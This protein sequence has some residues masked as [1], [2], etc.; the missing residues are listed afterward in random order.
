MKINNKH[1]FFAMPFGYA[2]IVDGEYSFAGFNDYAFFWADDSGKP[3]CKYIHVSTP[4]LLEWREVSESDFAAQ[5]R[6]VKE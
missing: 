4:S 3:I 1:Q 5:V 6:C 2:T